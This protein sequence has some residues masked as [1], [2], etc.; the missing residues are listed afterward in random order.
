M[1]R[2]R[3]LVLGGTAWLGREIA[4]AAVSRGHEV[5]CVARGESGEV[6]DGVTLVRADRDHEDGL[7]AVATPANT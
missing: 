3:I 7:A 6:P 2:R 4:R 1:T 5:T